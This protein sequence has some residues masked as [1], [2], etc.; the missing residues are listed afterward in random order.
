MGCQHGLC[1]VR[2]MP[3][4]DDG[5]ANAATSLAPSI[6]PAMNS[7]SPLEHGDA[8]L[9]YRHPGQPRSGVI[10]GRW[11]RRWSS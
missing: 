1:R 4:S 10:R 2:R 7:A 3:K 8:P 5:R 9:S 6:R 11:C